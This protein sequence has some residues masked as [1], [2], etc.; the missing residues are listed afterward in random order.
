MPLQLSC[1]SLVEAL[2]LEILALECGIKMVGSEYILKSLHSADLSIPLAERTGNLFLVLFDIIKTMLAEQMMSFA[3]QHRIM[4]VVV[5]AVVAHLALAFEKLLRLS[6]R[7][8][9]LPFHWIH[10]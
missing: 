1:F 8:G 10:Y 7:E 2:E 3:D 6:E 9:L 5:E 4:L